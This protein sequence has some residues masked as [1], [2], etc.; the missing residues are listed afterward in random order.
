M[1]KIGLIINPSAGFHRR[2]RG[3]ARAFRRLLD[4][5]GIVAESHSLEDLP[6]VARR[7]RDEG[8]EILALSGGDGTGS[9]TLTAFADVYGDE[10]LPTV[11]LLRGGTMNTVANSL[12]VPRRRPRALLRG[13]VRWAQRSDG[14]APP[15]TVTVHPLRVD[16]RLGFLFGVGVVYQFLAA[17][18][19]AGRGHPTAV[20][21][22]KVLAHGIASVA[23]GGAYARAMTAPVTLDVSVDG[24]GWLRQPCLTVAAGAVDQIGLGFR[25]FYK[26]GTAPG[27]FHILG[28]TAS[29]AAFTRVLP[30]V[31]R[32]LSMGP[33]V[34]TEALAARAS[35]ASPSGGLDYMVDGDLFRASAPVTVELGPPVEVLRGRRAT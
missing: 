4:G 23:V 35:V 2:D 17:Y 32:G 18:Y 22:A 29:A 8:V 6:T 30:R 10:P 15:D 19:E 20:T 13:L 33:D 26:A 14:D 27:R 25:P 28:I 16:G 11:A 24:V 34:A 5:A 31:H 3:A 1:R 12:G 21:A 9:A 7:F